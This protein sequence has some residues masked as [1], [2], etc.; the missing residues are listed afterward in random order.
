MAEVIR[1]RLRIIREYKKLC[2]NDVTRTSIS[3]HADTDILMHA[4]M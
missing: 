2:L 3:E 1:T 4:L